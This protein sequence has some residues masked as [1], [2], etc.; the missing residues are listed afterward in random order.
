MWSVVEKTAL[1]EAEVEYQDYT[2]DTIFV[3]FPVV[4]ETQT[5]SVVSDLMNTA[6]LIWT[7]TPWTIPGNRAVSYN[8]KVA[9]GLYEIVAA[10]DGNW[11]KTGDRLL[12]AS[13]L[14]PDVM[15]S[16]KVESFREVRPVAASELGGLLCRHP[17]SGLGGGYNF[18]IPLMDGDHVT[19]DAGTGFVHTA[20][21][22]GADDYNIWIHHQRALAEQFGHD[23]TLIPTPVGADGFYTKDAPGFEG[24]CVITA[25]GEKGDANEAV[26]NALKDAGMLVARSRL[27][28][29]YP[30]SWRSKKPIIFRNTPQ[31]FITMGDGGKGGLRE[32]ALAAIDA[33]EFFPPAGKNRLRGMIEQ[34]PDWV[35]SR[36]RAWGV[37]ICV[38]VNLL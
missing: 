19:D 31:W 9:Y 5:G 30:H 21:S 24:K 25:N 17:L 7:T 20:P 28:H 36:Q 8:P 22:H 18:S 4:G 12:L 13:R 16:M 23:F 33:T 35:I 32:T 6:V 38:F 27:Q 14:A 11:A 26:I 10:P 1:A 29:Q 2:S 37:P 3:K 15:K 34:R